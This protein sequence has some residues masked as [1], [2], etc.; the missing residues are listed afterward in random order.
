M[1][2]LI[3][4]SARLPV[5]L[6]EQPDGSVAREPSA[7]GVASGLASLHEGR[8]ATWIGWPGVSADVMRRAG[9]E[10]L[11]SLAADRLL[12]VDL[13][14]SEEDEFYGDVANGVLW[15]LFHHLTERIPLRITGWDSFEA[16]NSR[17]ADM[18]A[19]LWQ[20]GDVVWIHDYQLA[21]VPALLRQRCPA[22]RIGFFLHIPFP[23][24]DLFGVLPQR[25]GLLRGMLGADLVGVHTHAYSRNLLGAARRVLGL[26]PALE[27]VVVDDREVHVGV[28]PMGVDAT[29]LSALAARPEVLDAAAAMRPPGSPAML[30]GIDRLDYT[31]GIP[32]RLLAFELLLTRHPEWHG[33]VR[34]VQVAVPSRTRVHAYQR[35]RIQVDGIVGRINGRFASPMWTPVTYIYRSI[36]QEE[37]LALF[38]AADVMVVTPVR[39]GMNLVAKEFVAAR[40]DG[41]GVLV[42]SEFAGA[43]DELA[44]S[45]RVNPY[46][47]PATAEAYASA[48]D[49]PEPERRR[50]M[51]LL[52]GRVQS[53]DSARWAEEFLAALEVAGEPATFTPPITIDEVVTRARHAVN[54]RVLLDYDGTLVPF[55]DR[56]ELAAPDESLLQLLR[57]LAGRR[58]TEVHIVSGRDRE[59]LDRWFG[60]LPLGLH[61]EHG[62]WSRRAPSGAWQCNARP[63]LGWREPVRDVLVRFADRTPGAQLEE[64]SVGLAWHYRQV[65]EELASWQ[66]SELRLH[67][68]HMLVG[69][70]AEVLDGNHVIEVRPLGVNKALATIAVT[71]TA[72]PGTLLLALGDDVTDLQLFESLPPG[73]LAITVGHRLPGGDARVATPAEARAMLARIAR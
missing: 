47:L 58:R 40:T 55:A 34:L 11:G 43:S 52:R 1:R 29:A 18:I 15:P 61:A 70:A 17:F 32:R 35:F 39:D 2:R 38:R 24:P 14:Q 73:G 13:P 41:D 49:M 27:R 16:V 21:L 56:P 67:L 42:L 46:D 54:L 8:D 3:L 50:R 33:R 71:A 72:P 25:E 45:L 23:A 37:L 66:V 48:L 69:Q 4:V 65:D 12:P 51:A 53:H 63:H 62:L 28:F 59:D 44:G 31:K 57:R 68:A 60:Q 20:P 30:L 64:K 7:G 10:V 36:P 22:A 5:T 26:R 6:R 19:G 9:P